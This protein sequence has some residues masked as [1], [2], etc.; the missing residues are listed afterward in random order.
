MIA[1][2]GESERLGE[3]REDPA[4]RQ[5][6]QVGESRSS[7]DPREAILPTTGKKAAKLEGFAAGLLK[8]FGTIPLS[9][10]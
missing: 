6:T 10:P 5:N 8:G 9:C 2:G 1:D 3:Y 4:T 7:L